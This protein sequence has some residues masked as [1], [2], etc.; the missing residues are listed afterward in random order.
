MANDS[1]KVTISCGIVERM[2]KNIPKFI[3]PKIDS[4]FDR[5]KKDREKEREIKQASNTSIASV[6][7][8]SGD[9]K[10]HVRF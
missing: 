8:T 10:H 7:N 1:F 9:L 2:K 6:L 3:G 5:L 4:Q